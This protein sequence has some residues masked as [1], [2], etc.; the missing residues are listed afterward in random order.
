LYT[1]AAAKTACPEGW[2]L[3]TLEEWSALVDAAAGVYWVAGSK[4]KSKTGWYN[5]SNGTDDYGF[6]ALPG[7]YR[8]S[9]GDF[10]NARYDGTWWSATED[11]G[12]IAGNWHMLHDNDGVYGG[13]DGKSYGYSVRCIADN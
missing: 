7:G 4:L 6:S 11:G 8:D 12:G 5:N 10:H 3:P 2:H 1:W 9:D 13:S